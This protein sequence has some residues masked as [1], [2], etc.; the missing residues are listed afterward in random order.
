MG[1]LATIVELSPPWHDKAFPVF[2]RHS[3]IGLV[4]NPFPFSLEHYIWVF[5]VRESSEGFRRWGEGGGGVPIGG[6]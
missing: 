6:W 2:P 1:E 3:L 5:S 4:L